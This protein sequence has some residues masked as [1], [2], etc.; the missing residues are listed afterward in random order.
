MRKLPDCYHILIGIFLFFLSASAEL[1]ADEVREAIVNKLKEQTLS[2]VVSNLEVREGGMCLFLPRGKNFITKVAINCTRLFDSLLDELSANKQSELFDPLLLKRLTSAVVR[3]RMLEI[4]QGDFL[5]VRTALSKNKSLEDE[6][7][8]PVIPE[9]AKLLKLLHDGVFGRDDNF[10]MMFDAVLQQYARELLL[11]MATFEHEESFSSLFEHMRNMHP[12]SVASD[13]GLYLVFLKGSDEEFSSFLHNLIKD[14]RNRALEKFESLL[15]FKEFVD[16]SRYENILEVRSYAENCDKSAV[17]ISNCDDLYN[18]LS[19]DL[20]ILFQENYLR[21]RVSLLLLQQDVSLVEL[22]SLLSTVRQKTPSYYKLIDELVRPY[23][24]G[25][26]YQTQ[27]ELSIACDVLGD[28]ACT[29]RVSTSKVISR[30]FSYTHALLGVFILS[31]ALVVFLKARNQRLKKQT[32]FKIDPLESDELNTK[33][34]SELR[35]LRKAFEL[36]PTDGL[37]ELHRSY[38]RMVFNVH[39]DKL[40][41]GG[42]EFVE[43]QAQYLKTKELLDRLEK[44]KAKKLGNE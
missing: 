32:F 14:A 28:E 3:K 26:Q 38:R 19:P 8:A 30:G 27:E 37:T 29:L 5:L 13:L 22:Q 11:L 4:L 6:Q 31:C 12:H 35:T 34:R 1:T 18:V 10:K 2:D 33:E 7:L 15:V 25:R 16:P 41:D 39:P 43:L 44:Q 23:L 40:K 20:Q 17:A 36:S 42:R 21:R 24:V 9:I